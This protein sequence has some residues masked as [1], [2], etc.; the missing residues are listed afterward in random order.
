[1]SYLDEPGG[2]LVSLQDRARGDDALSGHLV[3][4]ALIGPDRALFALPVDLDL[5]DDARLE[6]LVAPTAPHDQDLV[7][8]LAPTAVLVR[9]LDASPDRRV[10]LV[11]LAHGSRYT[12]VP[13]SVSMDRVLG[14][15]ERSGDIWQGAVDLGLVPDVLDLDAMP[16][17]ARLVDIELLQRARLVS[18]L[19]GRAAREIASCPF[20]PRTDCLQAPF[21][22]AVRR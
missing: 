2:V 3:L 14:A 4:G 9:S 10:A 1:M 11:T 20:S 21:L 17:L 18:V 13:P 22:P 5:T 7:E 19:L 15:L 12:A 16:S 8:H 6:I